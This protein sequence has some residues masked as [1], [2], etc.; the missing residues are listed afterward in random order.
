MSNRI[1]FKV[2]LDE[3]H[4]YHVIN[5]ETGQIIQGKIWTVSQIANNIY[6]DFNAPKALAKMNSEN[7]KAKYGDLDDE[8]ILKIWRQ[9]ATYTARAGVLMHSLIEKHLKGDLVPIIQLKVNHPLSL[10][11]RTVL[12]LPKLISMN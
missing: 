12:S 5:T 1:I 11:R 6:H 9:N 7:R 3:K 10:T 2:T 8:S 4:I